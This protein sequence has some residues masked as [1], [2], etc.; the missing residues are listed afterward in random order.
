LF[1]RVLIFALGFVF[2]QIGRE[3]LLRI[4]QLELTGTAWNFVGGIFIAILLAWMLPKTRLKRFDLIVLVWLVLFVV[5]QFSN[6]V[7]AYFFTSLYSLVPVFVS[8]IFLSLLTTLVEGIMAA[9]LFLRK[10]HD[11]S[12]VSELSSHFKERSSASWAWRI[13]VSSVAYFPIYF[14]FG[15]LIGPFILPYYMNPSF[16]LKIPSFA[17]IIP[18]EFLRGFLYVLVLLPIIAAVQSSR[19]TL[20]AVLASVL[21][22]PGA[23][24]PL[25]VQTSLPSG[26][27]P[28][29]LAEILGDSI[30]YGAVIAY[31]LGRKLR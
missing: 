4:G 10:I 16:G 6:L 18:L 13:V 9:A 27:V 21:Y 7:E 26:I 5:Q 14:I 31:L 17:V 30:A 11:R 19:R 23:L 2:L 20:V 1:V 15:A 24:V 3:S 12:L 8:A 28:F 25:I 22:V 29:H